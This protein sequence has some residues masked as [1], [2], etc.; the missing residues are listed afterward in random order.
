MYSGKKSDVKALKY[1]AFYIMNSLKLKS[2][3]DTCFTVFLKLNLIYAPLYFYRA[4]LQKQ[5]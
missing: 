4:L 2:L 3:S 5:K 1:K